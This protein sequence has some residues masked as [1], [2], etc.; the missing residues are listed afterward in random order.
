MVRLLPVGAHRFLLVRVAAGKV[1]L[2][3]DV[4]PDMLFTGRYVA[5]SGQVL[6]FENP[7][8]GSEVQWRLTALQKTLINFS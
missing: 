1:R 2:D 3:L 4:D 7:T 6:R 8:Q 5:H